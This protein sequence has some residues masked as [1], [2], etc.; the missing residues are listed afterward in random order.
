VALFI[1]NDEL[2]MLRNES[3]SLIVSKNSG[4]TATYSKIEAARALQIPI[5][6]ID[7]PQKH[8]IPTVARPDAVLQKLQNSYK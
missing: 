5:V 4:G 1:I 3:I 8:K 2:Q 7:R 6:M